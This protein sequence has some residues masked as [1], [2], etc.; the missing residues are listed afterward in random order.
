MDLRLAIPPKGGTTNDFPQESYEKHSHTPPRTRRRKK[1]ED[2]SPLVRQTAPGGRRRRRRDNQPRRHG[3][4]SDRER[5]AS[6]A[7]TGAESHEGDASRRRTI[8]RDRV[9]RRAGGDGPAGRRPQPRELR[10]VTQDRGAP[11]HR[12]RDRFSSGAARQK[13]QRRK[14]KDQSEQGRAAEIQ[15]NRRTRVQH[16]HATRRTRSH[17]T[18]LARRIDEDVSGAA[19]KVRPGAALR[20]HADRRAG[21]ETGRG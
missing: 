6:P 21:A 11:R 20:S 14:D 9:D 19:E 2:Q 18:G 3:R 15:I 13:V 8:D 12:A 7:A 5:A 17:E 4:R 10:S 16:G 1:R